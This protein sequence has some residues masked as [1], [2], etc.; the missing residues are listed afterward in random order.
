MSFAGTRWPVWGRFT[1]DGGGRG[2]VIDI[3]AD[4]YKSGGGLVATVDARVPASL[5]FPM[6]EA[7]PI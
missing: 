4:W 6:S 3:R 5:R 7:G 1:M 2:A